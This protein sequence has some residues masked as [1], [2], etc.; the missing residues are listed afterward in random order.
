MEQYRPI[1]DAANIIKKLLLELQYH[2]PYHCKNTIWRSG[3]G[4]RTRR[5]FFVKSILE[6]IEELFF[7]LQTLKYKIDSLTRQIGNVTPQRY[8]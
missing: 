7:A 8:R 3:F 1:K 5:V 4:A 6:K 2:L